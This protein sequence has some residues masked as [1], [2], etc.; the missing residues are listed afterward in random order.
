MKFSKTRLADAVLI[1][2]DRHA[3]ERGF[4]ARVFCADEF[5]AAG[6]VTAFP[7]ANHSHN[8]RRGTLRGM[9]FQ[10]APHREAKLVRCVRGAIHDVIVDLRPGSP[11]YGRWQG[12]D[13]TAANGRM[14]YVPAGFAH[15]LQTL[16]DDTDVTYLV[17]HRYTPGAEGGL[18]WDDPSLGIAW[19][20]PVAVISAKDAA[21]PDVDLT[22]GVPV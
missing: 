13:L 17:S 21:W 16:E 15:G 8:P 5:A 18:R 2:P 4:F 14:L 11:S 12:F 3:D 6:L 20:L 10:R 1:D 9:H 19:P 22:H 7:Q